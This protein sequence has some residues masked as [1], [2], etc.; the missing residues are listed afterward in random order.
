MLSAR[1]IPILVL[2]AAVSSSQVLLI[3]LGHQRANRA[4]TTTT[5]LPLASD[6]V[7]RDNDPQEQRLAVQIVT[8]DS[9]NLVEQPQQE[10][11][12]AKS[13]TTATSPVSFD[14]QLNLMDF[15]MPDTKE[16]QPR[17]T[18]TG[19]RR[20]MPKRIVINLGPSAANGSHP[21]GKTSTR[22]TIGFAPSPDRSASKQV[23]GS[24][25]LVA[26]SNGRAEDSPGSSQSSR[27]GRDMRRAVLRAIRRQGGVPTLVVTGKG[28]QL[29]PASRPEA[30]LMLDAE[31]VDGMERKLDN[32]NGGP[33]IIQPAGSASRRR[34]EEVQ[35]VSD[36]LNSLEQEL[37]GL[38]L[39]SAQ[40]DDVLQLET[41]LSEGQ[42]K[43]NRAGGDRDEGSSANSK[44]I[45]AAGRQ[46]A[47]T[48]PLAGRLARDQSGGRRRRSKGLP[49][50]RE[51]SDNLDSLFNHKSD[52]ATRD[53]SG[54]L[55]NPPTPTLG[56]HLEL[57][58]KSRPKEARRD[59]PSRQFA[60]T[61]EGNSTTIETGPRTRMDDRVARILGQLKLYTTKEQLMKV[62]RDLERQPTSLA[63]DEERPLG[64]GDNQ[65][66]LHNLQTV[67]RVVRDR[68]PP[69]PVVRDGRPTL[70]GRAVGGGQTA[71][72]LAS[73]FLDDNND[74][75]SQL[76]DLTRRRRVPAPVK[77]DTH[78][79]LMAGRG[80]APGEL[81]DV[82]NLTPA[83]ASDLAAEGSEKQRPPWPDSARD[84]LDLKY[85]EHPLQLGAMEGGV[86]PPAEESYDEASDLSNKADSNELGEPNGRQRKEEEESRSVVADSRARAGPEGDSYF[87]EQAAE[88]A[89]TSERS[90]LPVGY[91]EDETEGSLSS[92]SSGEQSFDDDE[93]NAGSDGQETRERAVRAEAVPSRREEEEIKALELVIDELAAREREERGRGAAGAGASTKRRFE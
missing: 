55:P 78:E 20:V 25:N 79:A 29:D 77:E 54:E 32:D 16:S 43:L 36:D 57:A 68:P 61:V 33:N 50:A 8:T 48:P 17:A 23:M 49:G 93:Y 1:H 80:G 31:M 72:F 38:D 34:A 56:A 47:G 62:A 88:G 19:Q 70:N 69:P 18:P 90:S 92:P 75:D 4:A 60:E 42:E 13:P 26:K 37:A 12:P 82:N 81:Q 6:T 15:Q 64:N 67:S 86:G 41:S 71:R 24:A 35:S 45:E 84:Y 52:Y 85:R 11:S 40:R 66:P 87:D 21:M 63:G 30:R 5:R 83:E 39:S 46:I 73:N 74:E 7:G 10:P 53:G 14:D 58:D 3:V 59:P 89:A 22:L 28:G 2:I 65:Q 51:E 76:R 91:D 9:T 44:R 27:P